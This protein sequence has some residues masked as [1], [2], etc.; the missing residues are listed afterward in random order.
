L[1]TSYS[2]GDELEVRIEKIVPRGFGLAFAD[3]LTVLVPLAAPGDEL[4]VQIREV[5]KRLAFAEIVEMI[6]PGPDRAEPPCIYFGSCGGCDFQQLGY[7]AQLA[8]KVGI[9][10]DCLHRIARIEYEADI[11]VIASPPLAYRSR[12]RWHADIETRSVGYFRRD[13]HEVIDVAVCPILT[14]SL[15]STLQYVRGSTDWSSLTGERH[16]LEAA[17]GEHAEVSL[18]S[19]ES[20][21]EPAELSYTLTND[22]YAYSARTF[23][24]AN[25]FLISDLVE[26]AIGGASGNMAFDLYCGVGLFSLPLARRFKQVIGVEGNPAA[27][28]FAKKNAISAGLDNLKISGKSVDRFLVENKTNDVDF[29]LMAP[30]RSGGKPGALTWRRSPLRRVLRTFSIKACWKWA[31]ARVRVHWW[32]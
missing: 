29:V 21:M 5:K 14:P 9:I 15:Q 28:E 11:P 13:S 8:A 16:E 32:E 31:T 1:S 18:F 12:A 3:K 19:Y 27:V 20:G 23:F 26:T 30:P 22:R 2:I 17:V 25:K 24:Q 4:R 6:S 10:R 7:E